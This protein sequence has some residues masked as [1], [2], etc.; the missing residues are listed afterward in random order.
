MLNATVARVLIQI[1]TD[2]FVGTREVVIY[3][4][5]TEILGEVR[6]DETKHAR[7]HTGRIL[8]P[9]VRRSRQTGWH[10]YMASFAGLG[11]L[12]WGRSAFRSRRGSQLSS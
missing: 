6:A 7:E 10:R 2:A 11:S 12:E 9:P 4:H 1:A 8:L 3:N 5:I